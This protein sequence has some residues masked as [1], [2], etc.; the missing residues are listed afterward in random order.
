MKQGKK[1]A[2]HWLK[3]QVIRLASAK[4]TSHGIAL[5]FAVGTLVSIVSPPGLHLLLGLAVAFLIPYL[6]KVSVLI[7][8]AFWN[9]LLLVPVYSL[10]ISLGTIL[11]STLPESNF[12]L[13]ILNHLYHFSI[14]FMA[15]SS[16]IG[17]PVSILSYF[18]VK[19]GV[20]VY[21]EKRAAR[22]KKKND[23]FN[24]LT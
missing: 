11:L 17:I 9:P 16:I 4:A 3:L 24:Q 10:S 23:S 18:L 7:S 8:I 13:H 20:D 14:K 15:G 19:K 22:L 6:N 1:G 5:G 21:R 2:F 12:D